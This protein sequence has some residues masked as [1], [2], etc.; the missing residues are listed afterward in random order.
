MTYWN[1]VSTPLRNGK[2]RESVFQCDPEFQTIVDDID[3][4]F[5]DGLVPKKTTQGSGG[6]YFLYAASNKLEAAAVFKPTD[7]ESTKR[8]G[9]GSGE[10][11]LRE[12]A[13]Y[14][15][16]HDGFCRVP[17]TSIVETCD[18][19]SLPIREPESPRILALM[20][21]SS[22]RATKIGS[23]QLYSENQ[24]DLEENENVIVPNVNDA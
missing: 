3:L 24:G 4:G 5:Q 17:S 10:E 22:C 14:R 13:A 15:L 9:I 20:S 11:S 19:V 1:Q 2:L 18:P 8:G 21:D 16:D 6:A 23:M 12:V 7:E